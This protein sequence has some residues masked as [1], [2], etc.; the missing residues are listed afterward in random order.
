MTCG[1]D[2]ES[3]D[4]TRPERCAETHVDRDEEAQGSLLP[5]RE[6]DDE[7]DAEE[8]RRDEVVSESLERDD[9]ARLGAPLRRA[10]RA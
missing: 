5:E 8:L 10:D 7:L 3:V 9:E 6:E 4:E 1:I 2:D